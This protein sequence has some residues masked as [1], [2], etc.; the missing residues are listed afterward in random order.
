MFSRHRCGLQLAA[1]L[2]TSCGQ[3]AAPR[4]G[5]GVVEAGEDCDDG[6]DYPND[7][8]PN[9]CLRRTATCGDGVVDPR[10]GCDDGNRVDTDACTNSCQ[11]PSC[12]DGILQPPEICDDGNCVDLD[13]CPNTCMSAD[14]GGGVPGAGSECDDG[15]ARS[16][17][18][19]VMG[20][21]RARCGDGYVHSGVEACD[22][23]NNVDD[24]TCPNDCALPTCGDGVVDTG[25]AC[26]DGND[27]PTDACRRC[28]PTFCGDLTVQA[29]EEC[30]E[31]DP[32]PRGPCVAGCRRATCGDG[33]RQLFPIDEIEECDDGNTEHGDFCDS[34]CTRRCDAADWPG[35][36][37]SELIGGC[38][39]SVE[40]LLVSAEPRTAAAAVEACEALGAETGRD[41][42]DSLRF[43]LP[44][45]ELVRASG[46]ESV[47]IGL[48]DI[49]TEG[50]WRG[51]IPWAPL[52][53]DNGGPGG[54]EDCVALYAESPDPD[55]GAAHDEDCESERGFVCVV[56]L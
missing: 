29:G 33:V 43:G 19:C 18:S 50:E 5:N 17:D 20:C 28:L 27:D 53:P 37:A 47:W 9:D 13:S 25:E 40:C 10:E 11:T 4:C 22:D 16:T 39:R 7:L 41:V 12:G 31:G 54:N 3:P 46:A 38:V 55:Y 14:C 21:M 49:A 30:D 34:S 51:F 6:N 48:D 2:V 45:M 1:A 36:T 24:D 52:Q 42:V 35:F 23:G 32:Q 15:N 44:S 26:D 56:R 8:C